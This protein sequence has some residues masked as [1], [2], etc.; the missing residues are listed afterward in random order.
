M[1]LLTLSGVHLAVMLEVSVGVGAL[2]P[3]EHQILSGRMPCAGFTAAL[4]LALVAFSARCGAQR[5]MSYGGAHPNLRGIGYCHD[6]S[7]RR[8]E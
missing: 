5:H 3:Q 8:L 7:N 4:P 6:S 1:K 2:V